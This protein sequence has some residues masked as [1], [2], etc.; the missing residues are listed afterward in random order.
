MIVDDASNASGDNLVA[1]YSVYLKP[2]RRR[3]SAREAE[4]TKA[5][6]SS[7]D[8]SPSELCTA[9]YRRSNNIHG[10]ANY[11][12][13]GELEDAGGER[14]KPLSGGKERGDWNS[15]DEGGSDEEGYTTAG[16]GDPHD[17]SEARSITRMKGKPRGAEV[18]AYKKVARRVKPVA[19]TL[20]EEFRIVRRE[21]P[22]PLD[23]MPVL[24]THPPEFKPQGRYTM[25]RRD[26]LDVR[27]GGFLWDIRKNRP[28][29]PS[30]N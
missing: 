4:G 2:S 20:P 16:E 26:E 1:L 17:W 21:I 28:S 10:V 19:T 27:R 12:G 15:Q 24:P 18:Y 30:L 29:C 6:R 9:L 8:S 23:G 25:A 13:L 14:V 11:E 5:A 22:N 3:A 7:T